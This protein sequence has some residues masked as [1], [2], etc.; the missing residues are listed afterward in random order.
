MTLTH[1]QGLLL[2]A[3]IV[4]FA[5]GFLSRRR[6]LDRLKYILLSLALFLLAGIAIGWAM[7]PFSK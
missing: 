4:S 2:F 6:A 7:Y 3:L 1:I 5:L